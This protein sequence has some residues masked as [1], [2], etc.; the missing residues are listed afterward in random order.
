MGGT[1]TA[2]AVRVLDGLCAR[3]LNREFRCGH[4]NQRVSFFG[5]LNSKLPI[6]WLCAV[7]A[8]HYVFLLSLD[9]FVSHI[10]IL[11]GIRSEGFCCK[12]RLRFKKKKKKKKKK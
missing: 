8:H 11:R 5:S 6:D 9:W 10:K 2:L 7:V 1:P 12:R 3:R 4:D